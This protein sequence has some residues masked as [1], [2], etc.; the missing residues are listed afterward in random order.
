MQYVVLQI[1]RYSHVNRAALEAAVE[2]LTKGDIFVAQTV[3]QL[4]SLLVK[5]NDAG[6]CLTFHNSASIILDVF[7]SFALLFAIQRETKRESGHWRFTA[8]LIPLPC[9][10]LALYPTQPHLLAAPTAEKLDTI[11]WFCAAT[12]AAVRFLAEDTDAKLLFNLIGLSSGVVGA[13]GF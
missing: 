8:F 7:L 4:T 9:H 2:S 13:R 3:E 1:S 5:A 6:A 12:D 10:L 11:G